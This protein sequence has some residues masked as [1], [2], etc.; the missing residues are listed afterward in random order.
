MSGRKMLGLSWKI[1]LFYL[2][3]FVSIRLFTLLDRADAANVSIVLAFG[4]ALPFFLRAAKESVK[5]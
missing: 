3:I 1:M 5:E 2:P 4:L